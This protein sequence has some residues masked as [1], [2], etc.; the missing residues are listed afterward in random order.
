MALATMVE[1]VRLCIET[2]LTSDDDVHYAA[3]G[4]D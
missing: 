3:G 4:I 2:A 1:A